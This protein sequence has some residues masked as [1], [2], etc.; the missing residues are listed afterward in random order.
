MI[1]GGSFVEIVSPAR[2][3]QLFGAE[4]TGEARVQ[5]KALFMA[6]MQA[7]ARKGEPNWPGRPT[8]CAALMKAAQ[9][10]SGNSLSL[11]DNTA[12]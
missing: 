1:A 4:V 6:P 11:L 10:S 5:L 8:S 12:S 9:T 2:R 7:K 3:L